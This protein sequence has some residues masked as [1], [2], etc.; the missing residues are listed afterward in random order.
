LIFGVA[1]IVKGNY[2]SAVLAFAVAICFII[3]CRL[4]Y[5]ETTKKKEDNKNDI[6]RDHK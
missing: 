6:E 3:S 2:L 5:R 4:M 1:Y